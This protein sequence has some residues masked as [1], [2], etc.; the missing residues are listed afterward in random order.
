MVHSQQ[1]V[2]GRKYPFTRDYM[3]HGPGLFYMQISNTDNVHN[4]IAWCTKY[5]TLYQVKTPY[6]MKEGETPDSGQ[7]AAL[8]AVFQ[9]ST[10]Q[11]DKVLFYWLAILDFIFLVEI[12]FMGFIWVQLTRVLTMHR[13]ASI[14]NCWMVDSSRWDG[15]ALNSVQR[16]GFLRSHWMYIV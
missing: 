2:H 14:N 13:F 10:G 9:S 5:T 6:D 15:C 1:E 16:E 11:V 3:V 7:L 12:E 4:Q 8:K